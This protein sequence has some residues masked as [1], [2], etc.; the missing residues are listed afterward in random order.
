MSITGPTYGPA[1][2]GAP[3]QLVILLHGYGSDGHDL[4]GLA[5][6]WAQML[7]QAEFV[8]PNAPF[9]CELAPYGRQWFGFEGR[10]AQMILGETQT[11][12]A[13][14]NGFIDEQLAKRG[15]DESALALVGFSQGTMMSLHVAP[16]RQ[17][18]AAAVVGYS[19]RL[20]A[21]DLLPQEIKSRPR[22]LLV[23]GDA[24]PV[25]PFQ[26]LR[27]AVN[28]LELVGIEVTAER[29]PRLAHGID[30]EGLELG[31]H[32]LAGAFAAGA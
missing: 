25:V 21:P 4:L 32:F 12:A 6:H 29:R 1:A 14:L 3:R 23:H 2:A 20:I 27:E 8:S 31:G 22:V 13:I 5:P 17:R 30:E 7:P 26:S 19:G 11:A 24:D 28:V 10:D 16:R 18:P 9:P 15:L